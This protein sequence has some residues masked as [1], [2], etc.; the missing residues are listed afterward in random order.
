MEK[1]LIRGILS[2]AVVLCAAFSYSCR[3]PFAREYGREFG[4]A[5]GYFESSGFAAVVDTMRLS[6]T[7]EFVYSIVA[8][9]VIIYIRMKDMIET[10]LTAILYIGR[11]AEHGDF[12][13]GRFQMKPSFVESIEHHVR[14]DSVLRKHYGY[15]IVPRSS[16]RDEKAERAE[17][18]KRLTDDRWQIRYAAIVTEIIHSRFPGI[19]FGSEREKLAF[20]A[21][22]YNGGFLN[23]E[24]YVRSRMDLKLFPRLSKKNITTPRFH[25]PYTKRLTKNP[26]CTV[27]SG[28]FNRVHIC[29]IGVN[30]AQATRVIAFVVHVVDREVEFYLEIIR[31]I[32]DDQCSICVIFIRRMEDMLGI[33][34]PHDVGAEI[35]V[36]GSGQFCIYE[37]HYG[38]PFGYVDGLAELRVGNRKDHHGNEPVIR[39]FAC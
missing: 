38:F 6:N 28:F 36:A 12:S 16:S 3:D 15:C 20:Y 37:L 11:G 31:G 13:V 5:V 25:A 27:H 17:R 35:I 18:M 32:V 19:S 33:Y 1:R 29:L 24:S 21:T 23:S 34:I 30:A 39:R 10:Q 26:E 22:A 4:E 14:R 2:A 8:P 9:E 7:P